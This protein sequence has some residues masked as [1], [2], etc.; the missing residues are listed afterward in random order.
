MH[1]TTAALASL[2]LAAVGTASQN[3][4][5]KQIDASTGLDEIVAMLDSDSYFERD[6]ARTAL[7]QHPGLTDDRIVEMLRSPEIAPE[8]SVALEGILLERFET[9]PVGAVG[10]TFDNLAVDERG[11]RVGAT[12]PDFPAVRAGLVREGDVIVSVDGIAFSTLGLNLLSASDRTTA[13]RVVQARVFSRVPGESVPLT[14]IR[15]GE[16]GESETLEIEIPLGDYG[17]HRQNNDPSGVRDAAVRARFSRLVGDVRSR[18]SPVPMT[19]K[20]WPSPSFRTP[21]RHSQSAVLAVPAPNTSPRF[22]NALDPYAPTNHSTYARDTFMSF[23]KSM[24]NQ[25]RDRRARIVADDNNVRIRLDARMVQNDN[26]L[27]QRRVRAQEMARRGSGRTTGGLSPDAHRPVLDEMTRL[28]DSIEALNRS[29]ASATNEATRSR[30]SQ[31]IAESSERLNELQ[32]E[33]DTR[34]TEL[35]VMRERTRMSVERAAGRVPRT[36]NR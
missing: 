24:D 20:A 28:S 27:A 1:R 35:A 25:E 6:A 3:A 8:S 32:Q 19:A 34:M 5:E 29:L 33:L 30:L 13:T 11:V 7:A 9:L 10:V 15:T 16:A 23:V 31:R 2:L 4:P 21:L 22:L 12:N 26:A 17:M 18:V 14:L 36:L